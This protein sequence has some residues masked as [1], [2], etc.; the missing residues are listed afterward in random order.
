MSAIES[1]TAPRVMI[2]GTNSGCGKTT[3]VCAVLKALVN[4]G[5][6]VSA[7]K[8]GPDYIDPMFHEKI[9]GTPSTNLDLVLTGEKAVRYLFARNADRSAGKTAG[10]TAGISILEGVMGF[11]DG[12]SPENEY[13]SSAHLSNLLQ[14]PVILTVNARAASLSVA[15]VVKGFREFAPNRIAGVILN[16]C[17]AKIFAPLQRVIKHK[18]G[19]S[20]LGYLPQLPEARVEERHLGLVT[21]GEIDRLKEKVEILAQA[22]EECIDLDAL[23]ALSRTAPPLV[24]EDIAFAPEERANGQTI[25]VARDKAFCF[26]YHDNFSLFEQLGASIQFFSPLADE[27][28]PSGAAGLILGGGYP[29]LYAEALGRN[30]KTLASVREAVLDHLPTIAECGGFMFLQETLCGH[31]M[32]G[33][34]PGGTVMTR[35]LGPFGYVRLTARKDNLLCEKGES[36]NAHEFHYST[37]ENPGADFT[38]EKLSTGETYPCVHAHDSLFAGYPHMHFRGSTNFA[39]RFVRRLKG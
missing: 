32:A 4:R 10:K 17:P 34:I 8:C 19:V 12:M 33:V 3:A 24:Y 25:A 9:V 26:Y 29:E 7:F 35:K 37:C 22:A 36:I 2:A 21:A 11:Y 31:A 38:A 23:I 39:L 15:A 30:H 16:H 20:V 27:P 1:V 14:T 6:S 28:V 5:L 13:A 18:T